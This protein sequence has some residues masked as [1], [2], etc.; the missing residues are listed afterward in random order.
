MPEQEDKRT[1]PVEE[2]SAAKE[3]L[4]GPPMQKKKHKKR[5]ASNGRLKKL[6]RRATTQSKG[7]TSRKEWNEMLELHSDWKTSH[8]DNADVSNDPMMGALPGPA[9]TLSKEPQD[10]T[11]IENWQ[12][13]EGSDHRDIIMNLLFRQSSP[14]GAGDGAQKK[15]KR[16][17]EAAGRD[18]MRQS[19]LINVPTL[20]S[21]SNVRNLSGMG[22][23]AVVEISIEDCDP[24]SPC[25]L[26]PSERLKEVTDDSKTT[27]TSLFGNANGGT[28]SNNSS[29]EVQR[30]ITACKVKLF[31]GNK[32][33]RCISDV[34]MFLPPPAAQSEHDTKN[35]DVDVFDAIFDLRL[36]PKQMR[37][38]GYPFI[39][40]S[41]ESSTEDSKESVESKIE[42]YS[43]SDV[44][45]MSTDIALELIKKVAVEVSYGDD[46]IENVVD[47]AEYEHHVK[48]F[49][50]NEVS[51]PRRPKIF[52]I[53]CE[54]VQTKA[55]M[56]L[57]RV[58]VI[59]FVGSK[60]GESGEEKSILVLGEF[61]LLTW[62]V[63]C[64]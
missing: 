51:S 1:A 3:Q 46:N 9:V 22:G 40:D 45:N 29:S 30:I 16:K 7:I 4:T 56:E 34:L 20:P 13:T 2:A 61:V 19:S 15:K 31:Q 6:W 11:S 41:R 14:D 57:A 36:T 43:K 32:Y 5:K 64:I 42:T 39:T 17:L 18:L 38:E 52:S 10:F 50:R 27:W 33:P 24:E 58:S 8:K 35:E 55:G 37:S 59:E 21:W 23:L 54:M 44:D 60:E 63:Y 12:A 47:Y 53:D 48:T 62:S 28:K 25:P 26:M 49:S